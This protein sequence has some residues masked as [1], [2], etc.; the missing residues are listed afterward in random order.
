MRYLLDTNACV[1]YLTGRYSSVVD[2]LRQV[3]S[4]DVFVSSVAL[5]ELRYGAEKSLHKRRN[6]DRLDAFAEEVHCLDF[7]LVA[8]AI[9]GRVRAGLETRGTPI[10][11]YDMLIAAQALAMRLVLVTDNVREFMRVEG[12]EVENWREPQ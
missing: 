2:R 10:G 11:P 1:D 4:Q 8:A 7:D 6:L 3:S 12:L 9:Y 5:A